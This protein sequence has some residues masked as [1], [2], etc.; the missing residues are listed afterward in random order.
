MKLHLISWDNL[1]LIGRR[2]PY[3]VKYK[4]GLDATGKVAGVSLDVYGDCGKVYSFYTL[5]L[6]TR[7]NRR[8]LVNCSFHVHDFVAAHL[9]DATDMHQR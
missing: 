2:L 6:P 3:L 1:K 9:Q 4:A 5:T 8:K 7:K